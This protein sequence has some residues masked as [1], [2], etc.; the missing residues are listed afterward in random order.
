MNHTSQKLC[1]QR[2]LAQGKSITP[3]LALRKFGC[4]SLSQRIGELKREK[5]PI[6]SEMVR[7][8]SKRVARYSIDKRAS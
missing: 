3:L 4:L 6:K 5:W 8:G 2:H 1:I 7:I